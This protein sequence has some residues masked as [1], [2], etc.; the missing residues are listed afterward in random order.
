MI[1]YLRV[2]HLKWMG[3]S[4]DSQVEVD[5][6]TVKVLF[7]RKLDTS[8]G[9]LMIFSH[10]TPTASKVDREMMLMEELGSSKSFLSS[11]PLALAL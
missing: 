9:C 5:K 11:T 1:T 2:D 8:I 4:E 7:L 6:T 10:D 3:S